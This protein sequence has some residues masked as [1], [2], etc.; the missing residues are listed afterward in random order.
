MSKYLLLLLVL[1]LVYGHWRSQHR[2]QTP[3]SRN[4]KTPL[5]QA[6]IAC[7]HCGLLLPQSE[8]LQHQGQ[9][10]CCAAHRDLGPAP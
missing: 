9:A 10:Y 4:H 1:A 7:A 5:P 3:P 8:A 2:R 6:M